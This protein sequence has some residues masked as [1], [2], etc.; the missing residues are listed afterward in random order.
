M[1]ETLGD[2]YG[3]DTPA[4]SISLLGRLIALTTLIHLATRPRRRRP[5]MTL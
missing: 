1:T 2:Y 3:Y 4:L 5:L